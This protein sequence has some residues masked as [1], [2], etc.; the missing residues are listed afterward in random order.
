MTAAEAAVLF[1]EGDPLDLGRGADRVCEIM[2]PAKVRTYAVDRNINYS[3][4]CVAQC[5]FCAFHRQPDSEEAYLLSREE[6]FAKIAE[7]VALGGTHVLLQGGL[8]PDLGIEF[9]EGLFG[10]IKEAFDI[11]IHA[12]SPPEIV[13]LA[14]RDGVEIADGLRRLQE[15]GLD[16]IPGGGAEILADEVRAR[17]SPR[18][19]STAE[20]LTVMRIAHDLG[21]RTTAT[22]MFGHVETLRHRVEHLVRVRELQDYTGGFTAFIPWTF[23]PQNTA[24]DVPPVGGVEYLRTLAVSRLVLDNVAHLQASWVTQG[25]KIAQVALRFGA[26]DMGGTMIEENV[27]RAAG[28]SFRLA[29]EEI[30]RL[31]E[32]AGYRAQ[33]RNVYYEPVAGARG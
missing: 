4:A 5:R 16:T 7:M 21:M 18:K 19:C 8:H 10:A 31:I 28:V 29:E 13:H 2:H 9:F 17:I 27:V 3:N 11:H 26:D 14:R 22:M 32:D 15:A 25:A 24:L 6:L 30:V 1:E 23:Q 12:L 33:Q 20:W